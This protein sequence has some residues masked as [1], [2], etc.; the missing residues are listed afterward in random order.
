MDR[1]EGLGNAVVPQ[2]AQFVGE[3]ILAY[4]EALFS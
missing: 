3:C 4:E 2:V 1:I